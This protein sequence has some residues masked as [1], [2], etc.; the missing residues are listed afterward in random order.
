MLMHVSF[1]VLSPYTHNPLFTDGTSASHLT[2]HQN[3]LDPECTGHHEVSMACA[4][5]HRGLHNVSFE[6]FLWL[7][8]CNMAKVLEL[9]EEPIGH[10]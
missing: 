5:L 9:S 10:F 4:F 1:V 6:T 2:S 7:P 8:V 3:G